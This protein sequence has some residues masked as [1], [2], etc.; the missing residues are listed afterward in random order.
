MYV[1]F[2]CYQVDIS[3]LN[4]VKLSLPT[5]MDADSVASIPHGEMSY[6]IRK[7]SKH[8]TIRPIVKDS[9]T[10]GHAIGPEFNGYLYI[11]KKY[12]DMSQIAQPHLTNGTVDHLPVSGYP[13]SYA[14]S[15]LT[16]TFSP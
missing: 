5:L 10:G 2:M 14:C 4:G 12:V 7:D 16:L 6:E 11:R 8:K 13:A 15:S 1:M 9:L 3:K